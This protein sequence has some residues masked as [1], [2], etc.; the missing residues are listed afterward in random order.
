M[1]EKKGEVEGRNEK[2]LG[3]E[4]KLENVRKEIM[5]KQAIQLAKMEEV[6]KLKLQLEALERERKEV[7]KDLER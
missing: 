5:E 4:K 6:D 2:N 7:M 3:Y 1:N